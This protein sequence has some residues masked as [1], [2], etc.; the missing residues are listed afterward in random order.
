VGSI[1]AVKEIRPQW[2][3]PLI[4]MVSFQVDTPERVTPNRRK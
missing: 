3:A 1:S 4:C 2:Q